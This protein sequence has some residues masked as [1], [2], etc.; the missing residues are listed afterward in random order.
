MSLR[1][2]WALKSKLHMAVAVTSLRLAAAPGTKKD[3]KRDFLAGTEGGVP[4]W[5]VLRRDL[6]DRVLLVSPRMCSRVARCC[7]APSQDV[8]GLTM[9]G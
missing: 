4:H 1:Q 5:V 7:H 3:Q 6:K 2:C 8:F 9:V